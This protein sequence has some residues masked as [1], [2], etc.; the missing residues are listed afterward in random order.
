MSP[1]CPVGRGGGGGKEEGLRGSS[2]PPPPPRCRGLGTWT[3]TGLREGEAAVGL[4]AAVDERNVGTVPG[5]A[6][7]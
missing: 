1:F 6:E 4:R 2:P 3:E 5:V 7:K